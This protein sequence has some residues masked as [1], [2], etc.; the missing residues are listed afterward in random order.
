MS[1]H[2]STRATTRGL[3]RLLVRGGDVDGTD[4]DVALT[5]RRAVLE[6][7]GAMHLDLSGRGSGT[8]APTLAGLAED[9]VRALGQLIHRTPR[10]EVERSL[11]ALTASQV[12]DPTAAVWTQVA[13]QATLAHHFWS[14]GRSTSRPRGNEAW[15]VMHHI[16]VLTQAV[17]VLDLDLAASAR[18]AGRI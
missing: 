14:Q 2:E 10:P 13:D 3:T 7:A 9:P 5:A 17:A 4:L 8:V 12:S 18:T 16:A 1:W 11:A 6:L 15:T